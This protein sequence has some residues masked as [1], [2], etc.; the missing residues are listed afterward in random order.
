MVCLSRNWGK[1]PVALGRK[2]SNHIPLQRIND[3]I[4]SI[5][6]NLGESKDLQEAGS[7]GLL[8][9]KKEAFHTTK[10]S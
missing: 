2:R 10:L 8:R 4:L 3:G 7:K 1:I 5:T 9:F 6:H